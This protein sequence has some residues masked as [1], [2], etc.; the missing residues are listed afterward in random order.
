MYSPLN[1]FINWFR[2][3]ISDPLCVAYTFASSMHGCVF[4]P[5]EPCLIATANSSD[6]LALWDVRK[7]RKCIK[8]HCQASCYFYVFL[9]LLHVGWSLFFRALIKYGLVKY[10]G[11]KSKQKCMS[12]Q[13][14]SDGRRV[15]GLRRR[16]SPVLYDI[17]S[18]RT[19]C[20]FDHAGYY[21]SCTMKSCCFAGDR[22][23][24]RNEARLILIIFF[25]SHVSSHFFLFHLVF[26]FW[27]W[28]L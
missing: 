6:G 17:H 5:M 9:F 19:V 23:Q 27:L 4:N 10:G 7:P 24:V 2:L 18:A 26:N 25:M 21:N 11:S 14:S 20:N 8:S 13:I 22:D 28:W 1:L 15:I 12:V 16:L 3:S